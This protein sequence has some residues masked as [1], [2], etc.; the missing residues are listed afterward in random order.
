MLVAPEHPDLNQKAYFCTPESFCPVPFEVDFT[1]V[2]DGSAFLCGRRALSN[3]D[4]E[5]QSLWHCFPPQV[6]TAQLS[7]T[8][9]TPEVPT[10]PEIFSV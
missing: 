4:M 5:C 6:T 3:Q 9:G 8:L 7:P 2:I 10:W 1:V